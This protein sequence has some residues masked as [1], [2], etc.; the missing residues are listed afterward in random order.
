MYK[1]YSQGTAYHIIIWT[2]NLTL[3]SCRCPRKHSVLVG[4]RS[5]L[6][7]RSTN[8]APYVSPSAVSYVP[9]ART[10]LLET[11]TRADSVP[12]SIPDPVQ[13]LR[14][15]TRR[16]NSR[17]APPSL[18]PVFAT[19]SDPDSFAALALIS[20]VPRPRPLS[21]K[22]RPTHHSDHC[23]EPPSF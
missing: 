14:I 4:S 23:S 22:R 16:C 11:D 9:I 18:Q 3:L 19:D 1:R 6:R 20:L 2:Q 12:T 15:M 10:R 17:T 7:I 5:G 13:A 21:W 8:P